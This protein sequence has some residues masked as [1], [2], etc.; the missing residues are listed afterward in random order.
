MCVCVCGQHSFFMCPASHGLLGG[1]GLHTACAWEGGY[2]LRSQSMVILCEL[3]PPD[4]SLCSPE[5]WEGWWGEDVFSTSEWTLD[6]MWQGWGGLEMESPEPHSAQ[7]PL[8]PGR[9]VIDGAPAGGGLVCGWP[10]SLVVPACFLVKDF[11][12]KGTN[13]ACRR[14]EGG[15][16]NAWTAA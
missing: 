5:S 16:C 7:P 1:K 8:P 6:R 13:D 15:L 11:L 12:V 10:R 14:V 3:S 9:V 2:K 4:Q